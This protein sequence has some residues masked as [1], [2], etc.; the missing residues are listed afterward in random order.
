[1]PLGIG[2]GVARGGGGVPDVVLSRDTF[3]DANGTALTAHAPEV[4]PAWSEGTGGAAGYTIQGNRL[5]RADAVI[6]HAF[7]NAG[8]PDV[9]LTVDVATLENLVGLLIRRTDT[10]HYWE[11][12]YDVG[13]D[14]WQMSLVDGGPDTFKGPLLPGNVGRVTLEAKGNTITATGPGGDRHSEVDATHAAAT[15]VGLIVDGF[16][17]APSELDNWRVTAT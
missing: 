1:M 13:N 14:G 4:G 8:S 12:F 11:L 17:G 2:V 16:G 9:R 15:G 10:S 3:T 5:S 6:R 7:M